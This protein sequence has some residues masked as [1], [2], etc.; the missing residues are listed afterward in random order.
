MRTQ[1]NGLAVM[2]QEQLQRDPFTGSL[3]LFCGKSKWLLKLLDWNRN[4][5]CLWMRA[6]K[7]S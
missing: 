5:F 1:I 7:C 3:F 2:V 4:G 6:W